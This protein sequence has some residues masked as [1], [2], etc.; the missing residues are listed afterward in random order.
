MSRNKQ[1]VQ[2]YA[3]KL[4]RV[5]SRLS[6]LISPACKVC[7]FRFAVWFA[8]LNAVHTQKVSPDSEKEL[9]LGAFVATIR[10]DPSLPKTGAGNN[11]ITNRF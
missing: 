9:A 4:G 2:R 11:S 6:T 3:H 1:T 5:E 10:C 8:F 7:S